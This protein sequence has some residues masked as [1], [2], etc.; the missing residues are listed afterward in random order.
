[1]RPPRRYAG[2]SLRSWRCPPAEVIDDVGPKTVLRLDEIQLASE[3]PPL[4]APVTVRRD[5]WSLQAPW[6]PITE[7]Y[8]RP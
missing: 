5:V 1:M 4:P 3:L 2:S 8:A 6:D 7:A